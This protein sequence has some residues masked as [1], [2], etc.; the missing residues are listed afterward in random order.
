MGRTNLRLDM[1]PLSRSLEFN[2]LVVKLFPHRDDSISHLLD[3]GQPM[4]QHSLPRLM[5]EIVACG[6]RRNVPLLVQLGSTQDGSNQLS[7]VHWGTGVEWSNNPFDLRENPLLLF[8]RGSDHGECSSSF[9]VQSEVL[10]SEFHSYSPR[11]EREV[12]WQKTGRA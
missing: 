10:S 11:G 12:P 5:D 2:Q 1:S 9:T 8:W 3:L 7:T 6:R 4:N